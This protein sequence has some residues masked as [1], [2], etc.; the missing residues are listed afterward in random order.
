MS[1]RAK[2]GFLGEIWEVIKILLMA[3]VLSMVIVQFIRPTRVDGLSMYPTLDNNDYLVIN[4]ISRYTG[5]NRGDV[6]VFDSD[7]PINAV[8]DQKNTAKK[9]L[10]F[11]LQ[12]DSNT[13]DLVKRVIA[14]GG[15]HI[16]IKD[17]V[18]KV[19]DQRISEDYISE[20]NITEG[21][22]D[23]IV[24]EGMLFCMGDNRM[25][26]LDSRYP[27]VGFVPEK[28]LVGSVLVRLLPLENIG[29]VN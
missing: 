27:E 4:R 15:D 1:Q 6:V 5:V 22:I 9:V 2:K 23:T 16:T 17:G 3:V 12:D 14:V 11:V 10:D 18:V 28:K 7:M 21:N 26:S 8:S 19:N 24:P 25:R 29:R 13:K 20:G